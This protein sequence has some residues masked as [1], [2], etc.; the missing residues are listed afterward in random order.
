MAVPN[1]MALWQQCPTRDEWAQTLFWSEQAEWLG[2]LVGV[3]T[4]ITAA[5]VRS[6]HPSHRGRKSTLHKARQ[7]Q[8]IEKYEDEKYTNILI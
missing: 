8:K 7:S 2:W 3:S 5:Q 6:S 1:N 4:A